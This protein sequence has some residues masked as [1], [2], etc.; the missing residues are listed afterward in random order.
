MALTNEM[1][2]K[3]K[4]E[5]QNDPFMVGYSGMTNAQ[6][7][8]SLNNPTLKS[9]VVEY[10]EQAPISRILSGLAESPNIITAEDIQAAFAST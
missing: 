1:L 7:I 3:I 10:F 2:K 6:K 5:I 4:Q 9:K 8:N